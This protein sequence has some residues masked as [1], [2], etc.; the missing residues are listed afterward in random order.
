[1]LVQDSLLQKVLLDALHQKSS[2]LVAKLQH[3]IHIRKDE[4]ETMGQ[5]PSIDLNFALPQCV[6]RD[7]ARTTIAHGLYEIVSFH[8]SMQRLLV[9]DAAALAWLPIDPGSRTH[10]AN[11]PA[12]F[13]RTSL[14]S[15]S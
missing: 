9:A 4:L 8:N 14:E 10:A 12:D 13:S 15:L 6:M 3:M 1:V 5:N 7:R 2:H 11:H